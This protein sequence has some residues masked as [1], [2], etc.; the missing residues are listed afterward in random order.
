MGDEQHRPA[1]PKFADF[2]EQRVFGPGIE[3]RRWF[4]END[5][6]SVPE[7]GSSERN[8]LPLPDGQIDAAERFAQDRIVAL[9]QTAEELICPSLGRG[10]Y[11]G[12]AV[13]SGFSTAECNVI[14]GAQLV[15][16]EILED[17][18]YLVLNRRSIEAGN[19]D[20]IPKD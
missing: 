4:I 15:S 14:G 2:F 19:V 6:R 11:N 17:D 20:A 16:D 1:L 8:A 10:C 5:E 13:G 3:G 7:E 9:F 12:L 18:R